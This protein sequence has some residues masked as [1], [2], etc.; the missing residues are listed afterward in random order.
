MVRFMTK[1]EGQED[2]PVGRLKEMLRANEKQLK[3]AREALADLNAGAKLPPEKTAQ[4]EEAR[5]T[6]SSS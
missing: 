3:Q 6:D 4:S 5:Q 1:V 2:E